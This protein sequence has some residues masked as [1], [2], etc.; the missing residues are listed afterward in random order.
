M[1][2]AF[3]PNSL[4]ALQNAL[5]RGSGSRGSGKWRRSEG[6]WQEHATHAVKEE[7]LCIQTDEIE[8]N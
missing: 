4:A 2:D 3:H 1:S 6:G 7:C 8:Q 5:K